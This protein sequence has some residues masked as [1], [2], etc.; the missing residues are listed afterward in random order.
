MMSLKLSKINL[1][2]SVKFSWL[3][4]KEPRNRTFEAMHQYSYSKLLSTMFNFS[5]RQ[6]LAEKKIPLFYKHVA[7]YCWFSLLRNEKIKS[8]KHVWHRSLM[9]CRKRALALDALKI[10]VSKELCF[11]G[12]W[13]SLIAESLQHCFSE[14]CADVFSILDFLF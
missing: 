14:H 4:S 7:T 2:Q 12:W 8:S 9:F 13:N 1:T 5:A 3:V 6:S 10:L 11:V